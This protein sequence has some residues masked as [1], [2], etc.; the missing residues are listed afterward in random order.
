MWI[1]CVT[2]FFWVLG[3]FEKIRVRICISHHLPIGWGF[4]YY[5]AYDFAS[6]YEDLDFCH[7]SR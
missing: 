2:P 6:R 1:V 5:N 3:K 4:A 7:A